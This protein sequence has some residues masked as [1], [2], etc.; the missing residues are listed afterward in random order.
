MTNP[1]GLS[2]REG[3]LFMLRLPR[4]DKMQ[5]KKGIDNITRFLFIEEKVIHNEET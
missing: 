1:N 5:I 2:Y 3:L 4:G